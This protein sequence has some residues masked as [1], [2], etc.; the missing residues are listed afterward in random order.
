ML[1]FVLINVTIHMKKKYVQFA[2]IFHLLNKGRP[3]TNYEGSKDLYTLLKVKHIPKEHYVNSFGLS[4]VEN[5]QD[6]FL[7][8][9]KKAMVVPNFIIV[10]VH[11]VAT[12]GIGQ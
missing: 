12:I 3:M 10:S 5:M 4:I 9:F 11:E 8:S 2:T 6:V 1:D 7:A